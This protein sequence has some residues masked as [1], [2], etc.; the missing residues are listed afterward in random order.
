MPQ[1]KSALKRLRVDRKKRLHNLKIK[2]ELKK[3]I[4][5]FQSL[6]LSKKLD[7]AKESFKQV[8]SKL[9]KAVK[10]GIIHKNTSSRRKSRFSQ[11][12]AHIA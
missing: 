9:D 3:T 5:N 11:K 8:A 7:E 10:S 12:L 1:R 2:N 6:L 4:K